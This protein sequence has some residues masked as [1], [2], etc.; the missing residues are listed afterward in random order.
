MCLLTQSVDEQMVCE[1][2]RA[3]HLLVP[4]AC[5]LTKEHVKV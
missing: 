2:R 3:D 4:S 1:W 5:D